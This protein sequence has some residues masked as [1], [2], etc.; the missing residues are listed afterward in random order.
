MTRHRYADIKRSRAGQWFFSV[1]A[2]NHEIIDTSEA[3]TRRYSAIRAAKTRP[4]VGAIRV[5]NRK[6]RLVRT[7]VLEGS[8]AAP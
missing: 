1:R 5:F 7:I 4:D 6:G 3:Y 2:G 8:I